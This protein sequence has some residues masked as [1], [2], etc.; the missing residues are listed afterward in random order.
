MASKVVSL[1]AVLFILSL[2][3]LISAEEVS[4]EKSLLGKA[5]GCPYYGEYCDMANW[6]CP[7]TECSNSYTGG[8]CVDDPFKS[9]KYEG[10]SCGFF[11]AKC[12]GKLECDATLYGGTCRQPNSYELA[13]YDKVMGRIFI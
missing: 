8:T 13:L 3:Q 12:C 7:G 6:C 10:Q 9:C 2:V 4:L 11:D 1:C 5:L